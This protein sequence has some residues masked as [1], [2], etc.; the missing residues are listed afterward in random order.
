MLIA[1][2]LK[3][4]AVFCRMFTPKK[5]M[6]VFWQV[7][8]L[9]LTAGASPGSSFSRALIDTPVVSLVP[10]NDTPTILRP[11]RFGWIQEGTV[12]SAPRCEHQSS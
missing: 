11:N 1:F 12:F 2:C 3:I 4:K 7:A 9:L 8:V 6:A 5:F 10:F